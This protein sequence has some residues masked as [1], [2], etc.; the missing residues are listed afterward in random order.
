LGHEAARND[1]LRN[2]ISELGVTAGHAS[3]AREFAKNTTQTI[4]QKRTIDE[5]DEEEQARG[6]PQVR[7]ITTHSLRVTTND[8]YEYEDTA[9]GGLS[10]SRVCPL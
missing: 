3:M 4:H 8:E 9:L 6:H 2:H 1:P 5:S 7:T 10:T